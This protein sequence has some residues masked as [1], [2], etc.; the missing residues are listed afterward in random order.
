MEDAQQG[1]LGKIDVELENLM[2]DSFDGIWINDGDG[3]T[4]YVNNAVCKYYD[5]KAKEII[6]KN[7]RELIDTG[8][9]NGSA[10]L[11]AIIKKGIINKEIESRTGKRL[12]LTAR[13]ILK[14]GRVWRVVTNVRDITDL[15]EIKDELEESI[16]QSQKYKLELEKYRKEQK[17][18]QENL[19]YDNE[20]KSIINIAPRIARTGCILILGESGVGKEEAAKIIYKMSDFGTGPFIVVNCGAIPSTLIESELFGFEKG[21][22]TDAKQ[23][24]VGLF[25]LANGGTLFLDEIG[26]FPLHMQVKILRAIQQREIMRIGGKTAIKLNLL[27]IAATNKNIERMVDEGEFRED[28]FYRL[29]VIQI[30]IPPLRERKD[31]IPDFIVLFLNKFNTKHNCN[32]TFSP[33]ALNLLINYC[34][35]GNIRELQN[36]TESAVVFCP[37]N[38]IGVDYLPDKIRKQ[39]SIMFEQREIMPLRLAVEEAEKHM[40]RLAMEKYK[41]SRKAA[42]VLM[43]NHVTITRKIK[44]Y[45]L[46]SG[47]S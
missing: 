16:V 38:I 8:Y 40:I 28:L 26:D 32:K 13:P 35:P 44:K 10:A 5:V 39:N 41:S 27:I 21:A 17:N 22:F 6:G 14:D 31:S 3:N 4:L 43:V 34:W 25:E 42:E 33:K 12:L 29:N 23:Q 11:E 24:K 15:I 36:I 30:T 19:F 7:V 2:A 1:T 9:F 37:Y 45:K 20:V 46:F 18:N 47:N